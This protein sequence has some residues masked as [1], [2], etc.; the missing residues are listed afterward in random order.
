MQ[1]ICMYAPLRAHAYRD[2]GRGA[3]P[4][5]EL[6]VHTWADASLREVADLA[7]EGI[8]GAAQHT[9]FAMTFSLVYPDKEGRFVLRPVS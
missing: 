9:H 3:M 7:R 5:N 8:A 2:C 4:G 1:C 6:R